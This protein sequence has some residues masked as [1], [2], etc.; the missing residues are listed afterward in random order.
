MSYGT[1]ERTSIHDYL[2]MKATTDETSQW[3]YSSKI[4]AENKLTSVRRFSAVIKKKFYE[5]R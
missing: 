4:S 5:L 1:V 3:S 2:R